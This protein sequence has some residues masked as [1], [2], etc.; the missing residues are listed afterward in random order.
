MEAFFGVVAAV[1]G[2]VAMILKFKL[3]KVQTASERAEDDV[4]AMSLKADEL[5]RM[6]N[7]GK[8]YDV[9]KQVDDLARSL[10]LRRLRA[11]NRRAGG[12][13]HT[14]GS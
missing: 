11:T 7:E 12:E 2:I 10:R 9:V 13:P 3:S 8:A 4:A 6:I 14:Q 1:L 5:A